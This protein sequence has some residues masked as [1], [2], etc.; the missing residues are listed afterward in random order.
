MDDP[1]LSE[2]VS[3]MV[4]DSL[5]GLLTEFKEVIT[6]LLSPKLEEIANKFLVNKTIGDIIGGLGR[7]TDWINCGGY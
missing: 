4:T 1:K 7:S 5:A 3:Q 6:G 2:I